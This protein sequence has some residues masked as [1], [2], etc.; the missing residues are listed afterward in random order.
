MPSLL[1]VLQVEEKGAVSQDLELYISKDH[2]TDGFS[3]IARCEGRLQEIHLT[4]ELEV[5]KIKQLVQ[6]VLRRLV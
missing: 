5:A 6:M 2:V 1:R 3:L 4:T